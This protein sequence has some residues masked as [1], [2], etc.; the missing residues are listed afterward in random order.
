[1]IETRRANIDLSHL[2]ACPGCD[3]LVG[4]QDMLPG[5]KALCP[6]CGSP[7]YE[8]KSD[9]FN[10][11]LAVVITGLILF[12]PANFLSILTMTVLGQTSDNTLISGVIGLYREEFYWVSFLVLCFS[13][14]APL[15]KL[16]SLL[17]I[18]LHVKFHVYSRYLAA[19]FRF[20][21]MLNPWAMVEVYMVAILIAVIK[22]GDIAKVHMGLG[23]FCF[24]GLLLASTLA[25][26]NL[27]ED[28]VWEAIEGIHK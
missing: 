13:M 17:V 21:G 8:P 20:C 1:M 18:L 7:L 10:R 4:K 9:T 26:V 5:N 11:T 25:S 12:V 6:R 16:L 3:L 24:V 27:D 15:L 19:L 14:A 22:L 2:T 23:L 28:Q